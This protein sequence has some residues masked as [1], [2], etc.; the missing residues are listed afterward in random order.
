M[1]IIAQ[2][3]RINP[4]RWNGRIS[5]RVELYGCD[6]GKQHEMLSARFL[7]IFIYLESDLLHFNGSAFIK[8]DFM[9]EP[10]KSL[11]DF[12]RFRFKTDQANGLIMYSEGV[13]GDLFALNLKDNKMYLHINL[14]MEHVTTLKVGSLLDNDLWHDVVIHRNRHDIEFSV[15]RVRIK[16]E[17]QGSF[18]RLDL[19]RGFYVGGLP[20]RKTV[21]GDV[22]NFTGCIENLYI[23]ATNFISEAKE[24]IRQYEYGS[25]YHKTDGI[26][27][28]CPVSKFI[29]FKRNY[30]P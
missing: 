16:D 14:G 20:V 8:R 12:I 22:S 27:F 29:D 15:D 10:I 11:K 13:Q 4:V 19:D 1:P 24:F 9:H 28:S 2:F 21:I 3:I 6:Y 30:Q 23:N 17:I 26:L 5:L 18:S 7:I 25:K